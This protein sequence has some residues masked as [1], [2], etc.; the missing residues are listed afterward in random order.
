MPTQWP[1]MLSPI[2]PPDSVPPLSPPPQPLALG[3]GG[4]GYDSASESD[5]DDTTELTTANEA[6]A[7]ESVTSEGES[8]DGGAATATTK[9]GGLK[10]KEKW[11]AVKGETGEPR[12]VSPPAA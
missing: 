7:E 10:Q 12:P 8:I 6:D 5:D 3:G 9:S 2:T 4:G 11:I 1:A